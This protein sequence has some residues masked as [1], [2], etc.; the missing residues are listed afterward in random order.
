MDGHVLFEFLVKLAVF[1][2]L[3]CAKQLLEL[4]G[5]AKFGEAGFAYE[6]A[7]RLA[8]LPQGTDFAQPNG[9]R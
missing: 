4:I 7:E 3:G 5:P 6:F 2:K 8:L 1:A 9:I